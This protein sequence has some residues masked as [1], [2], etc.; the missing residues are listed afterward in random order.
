M[1]TYNDLLGI[2][3]YNILSPMYQDLGGKGDPFKIANEEGG[4][5]FLMGGNQA[6]AM[7]FDGSFFDPYTFEWNPSGGYGNSGTVSAFLDGNNVG[8]WTQSDQSSTDTFMEGAALAAAAFGGLGL[9]GAGPLGGLL[10]SS[11][12]QGIPALAGDFGAISGTSAL[13]GLPALAGDFGAITGGSGMFDL[14]SL[15]SGSNLGSLLNVGGN[16]LSG[17]LGSEA[18]S[19]ATDALLKAGA[20]SNELQKYIFDTIRADNQPLLDLRNATLPQIN[21]LMSNPSTIVND[22]GYQFGL[23]QGMK[24]LDMS[25][26]SNGMLYSGAQMK[27]AQQFG[28]DYASTKLTDSLNR[29][30]GVAGLGQVGSDSNNQAAA[31]YGTNV[32]NTLQ[33]MGNARASGYVGSANSWNNALGNA[34]NNWQFSNI[35]GG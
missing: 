15:F 31:N 19:D 22:P 2:L 17:Y 9:A 30:M 7:G 29:L 13:Q 8:S 33:N 3:G 35:W 16:L 24:S 5:D 28:Q 32:G 10:G 6:Q 1:A 25:A 23:D 27:G 14:G 12:L 11:S 4:A 34:F 18:S 21:S 20:D 26:A